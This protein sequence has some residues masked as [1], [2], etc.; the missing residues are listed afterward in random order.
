MSGGGPGMGLGAK[1][2]KLLLSPTVKQTGQE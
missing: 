2:H 1:P